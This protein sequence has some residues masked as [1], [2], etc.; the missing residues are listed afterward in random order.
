MRNFFLLAGLLFLSVFNSLGQV[1]LETFK[2]DYK[3]PKEYTIAAVKVTGTRFLDKDVLVM[4][5]GLK[6]GETIS[7]PGEKLSKAI[8]N[9][10]KQNLFGDV[11][12]LVDKVEDKNIFLTIQ[13]TERPRLSNYAYSKSLGKGDVDNIN[14]KLKQNKG[15]IVTADLLMTAENVARDYYLDKGYWNVKVEVTEVK[16][17]NQTNSVIVKLAVDPGKKVRVGE[18]VFEGNKALSDKQLKKAMDEIKE[19]KWWNIFRSGKFYASKFEEDKRLI[20]K[21]YLDEGYRDAR[22]T[23][24]TVFKKSDSRFKIA[25]RVNEGQQYHFRHITFSGNTVHPDSVLSKIIGIKKG[26][27]YNQANLDSRLYMDQSG[28]DISSLYMDDGYLFFQVNPT[29][30]KVEKDSIDIEIRLTEGQQATINRIIISGNDKTNDHVILRELRTRPGQK[31]SRAD[32]IRT[33]RELA[34]LG[35]FDPEQIGINPIPNPQ[36][37]TV[38]IEYKVVERSNDQIELSGGW[39]ANQIVGSLGLVLNNFS[40]RNA[41]KWRN[42]KPLPS[43]DGQRL[44]FR[45]QSNGRFFQ[46]YNVSFTEPWL[47]GKKPNALTVSAYTSI[48]NLSPLGSSIPSGINVT[49]VSV[50]LGKRLKKPDDFFTLIHSLNYQQFAVTNNNSLGLFSNGIANSFFFKETLSRNSIDQPIYPRSGANVS[51]TAQFTP[52]WSLFNDFNYKTLDAVNRYRWIEYHKW[53]FDGNWYTRLLGDL[54]LNTRIQYG[55]LGSY[56]QDY[57]QVPFGRYYVGGDG[58]Q[59]FVLDD[60]ELIGLRGYNN[61]S[62]TPRGASGNYLGGSVFQKYTME[63]RYPISL[64]PSATIYVLGFLEGGN[65]FLN[66]RQFDPFRNYRSAGGGIRIFLPMF[67]LLGLDWGYGFDVVPG[68]PNV[69]RG[70]IHISIGQQF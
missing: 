16:D 15:R 66:T 54:V 18:I 50:S 31:F 45:I 5:S 38:D 63:L 9:L 35:Y 59:G 6:V 43:G 17:T 23:W 48:Q 34:Q 64:N 3:N 65:S 7:V 11:Q 28:R 13:L 60:R 22:V 12:I 42:W 29:E 36:D 67:G 40:T 46:S 1:S 26:E 44:S 39:G 2:P 57:G 70:Q 69:N 53:R 25:I 21:R 10:W 8:Q 55:F 27:V 30:V 62:L 52:P 47:G 68:L 51:L 37:G 24:D 33:N 20:E 58:I 49:G 56:N 32:I 61:N 19:K 41:S 4:I 14:D